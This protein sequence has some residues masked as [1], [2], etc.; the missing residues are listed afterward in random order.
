[1]ELKLQILR[2]VEVIDE[3][4]NI[5]EFKSFTELKKYIKNK[6]T[7]VTEYRKKKK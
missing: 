4:S 3:E 7:K 6:S 2:L 5:L 1:M